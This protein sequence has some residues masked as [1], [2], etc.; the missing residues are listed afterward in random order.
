MRQM[1]VWAAAMALVLGA[2]VPVLAQLPFGGSATA[3]KGATVYVAGKPVE[4]CTLVF[5]G[6]KIKAVGPDAE[7]PE[8][9]EI[10]DLSGRVILPA[11]IDASAD[12]GLID[13]TTTTRRGS[14][15]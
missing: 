12:L 2:A 5:S 8:D 13:K 3:I 15:T 10:I 14:S 9:A 4:N 6:K 7:I 11:L 1:S